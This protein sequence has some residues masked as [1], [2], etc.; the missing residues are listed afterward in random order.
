MEVLAAIAE[1]LLCLLLCLLLLLL[2]LFMQPDK[3]GKELSAPKGKFNTLVEDLHITTAK[4]TF[5]SVLSVL[6]ARLRHIKNCFPIA[7]AD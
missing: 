3:R 2:L 5:C 1:P 4:T 6:S 7:L